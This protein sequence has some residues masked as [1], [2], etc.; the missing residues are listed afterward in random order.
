MD[1]CVEIALQNISVYLKK[2]GILD[3]L[4]VHHTKG[5]HTMK[6]RNLIIGIVI[7]LIFGVVSWGVVRFFDIDFDIIPVFFTVFATFVSLLVFNNLKGNKETR[8][9][10]VSF[11]F[12]RAVRLKNHQAA[13]LLLRGIANGSVPVR[14]QCSKSLF[15]IDIVTAASA[16]LPSN[17]QLIPLCFCRLATIRSFAF[18][19]LLLDTLRPRADL[20][21]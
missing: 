11:G 2:W 4:K 20:S 15:S 13:K 12:F 14:I 8:H 7:G 18:S 9:T 10:D 1:T 17:D 21:A 5:A 6:T 19:T 16:P 3:N